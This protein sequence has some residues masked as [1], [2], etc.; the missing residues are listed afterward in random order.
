LEGKA[1]EG[2]KKNV[3][4]RETRKVETWT[5]PLGTFNRTATKI[6]EKRRGKGI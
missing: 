2:K 1:K 6:A 3:R 4:F 5:L